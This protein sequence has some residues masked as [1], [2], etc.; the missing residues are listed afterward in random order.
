M[1]RSARDDVLSE[2]QFEQLVQACR[3]IEHEEREF[4]TRLAI[5][6]AGRLGLRVGEIAHLSRSW[7]ND[8]ERMVEVPAHEPCTKDAGSTCS[9]CASR[10][11]NH[12]EAMSLSMEESRERVEKNHDRELSPE[13]RDELAQRL[14][15]QRSIAY[16]DAIDRWWRPKTDAGAR[17][18]PY[19]WDTRT[20]LLVEEFDDRYEIWP[21]SQ[22]TIN[23]RIQTA[24][25]IAGIEDRV[26]PH[27]LRA[28]AASSHAKRDVSPHSLMAVMGWTNLNVARR[29]IAASSSSAAKEIR[30]AHR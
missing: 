18:I 2:R 28:T 26:Y 25:E 4:Q 16:E 14:I 10:A 9:Y 20:E 8:R 6:A 15:E 30:S 23:R 13:A 11:R 27:A 5:H 7:I 19:D 17:T 22:S 29:Y 21:T 12:V 3:Q 24:A 1:T